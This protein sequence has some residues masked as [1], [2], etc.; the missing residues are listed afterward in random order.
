[1]LLKI[2]HEGSRY[3]SSNIKSRTCFM[4]GFGF[5]PLY[6][7]AYVHALTETGRQADTGRARQGK[8]LRG[9][10]VGRDLALHGIDLG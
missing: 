1:M 6:E 5:D 9:S 2:L 3:N 8:G 4:W 7:I 10:R